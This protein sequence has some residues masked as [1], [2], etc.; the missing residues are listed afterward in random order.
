[1]GFPKPKMPNFCPNRRADDA[2]A[3]SV[4]QWRH[5]ADRY[6]ALGRYG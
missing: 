1:M 5:A 4:N 3:L 6:V 2:C